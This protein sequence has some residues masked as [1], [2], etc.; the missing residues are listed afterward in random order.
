MCIN[1]AAQRRESSK[2]LTYGAVLQRPA[3]AFHEEATVLDNDYADDV[4]LMEST[5]DSLQET[6]D[7]LCKY[8]ASML[9]KLT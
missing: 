9:P 8:A 4:A 3:A 2:V 1:L 6:N 7:L 5:K